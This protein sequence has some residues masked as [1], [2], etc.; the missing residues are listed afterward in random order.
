MSIEYVDLNLYSDSIVDGDFNVID[1]PLH[2]FFQEID[3]SIKINKGEIWGI[4]DNINLKKYIFDKYI[5]VN[6]IQNE[7]LKF[8]S[9]NCQHASDFVF[10]VK[11]EF[12]KIE[13]KELIYI[14]VSIDSTDINGDDKKFIQKFLVG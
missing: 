2:L 13:N 8:I 5:T 1:A 12:M 10:D 6:Q 9:R 4:S 3:L 7:V 11:V 14:N